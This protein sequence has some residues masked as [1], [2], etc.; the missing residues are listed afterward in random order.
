MLLVAYLW[1]LALAATGRDRG[2]A[3]AGGFWLLAGGW[4]VFFFSCSGSKLPTYILPAYP[5]LCLAVGEFVARTRWNTAFRT[6]VMVGGDG[7]GRCCS[8]ITSRCRGT[9][10]SARRTAGRNWWS[11]SSMTRT[12]TVV[13][14]PRNCDSLAFYTDR[15]DMRNV[16]TKRREPADGRLP[17]PP[18]HGDPVH[19]PRFAR[20]LQE[21]A[22]AEPG[23]RRDRDLKRKGT[24]SILDKLVGSTPVGTV[25][26]RGGRAE[27]TTSRR[28]GS[29]TA[30]SKGRSRSCFRPKGALDNSP[31]RKPG[32]SAQTKRSPEGA[33]QMRA[34]FDS[35]TDTQPL[36]AG[37]FPDA[38]SGR[39]DH[40]RRRR[41]VRP[42]RRP[43]M[44]KMKKMIISA[45][46]A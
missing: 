27:D 23:D 30:R 22:P 15:S 40:P 33:A 28:R 20:R 9:H 38:P 42:G 7:G 45:T 18:A 39:R 32:V 24:G 34:R 19:A 43:A 3:R 12:T 36:R 14:F 37:L 26:R 17:P 21:H 6:R 35:F 46:A 16:R 1:Q 8:R 4:C 13:C 29:R 10:A 41:Q 44:R 2:R 5:F 31:R 25:R 11:G